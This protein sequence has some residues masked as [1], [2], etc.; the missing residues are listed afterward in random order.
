MITLT[1]T[2]EYSF[3]DFSNITFQMCHKILVPKKGQSASP[4]LTCIF[5]VKVCIYVQI[6]PIQYTY[7]KRNKIGVLSFI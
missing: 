3:S 2:K 6:K 1:A 4:Q 5:Q 7:L